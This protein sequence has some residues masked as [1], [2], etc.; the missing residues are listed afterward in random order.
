MR[1]LIPFFLIP[2]LAALPFAPVAAQSAGNY[3][4]I[5]P[6]DTK[7]E[8]I[9]KAAHV[10]PSPQQYA[11]QKMEFNA[12]IH[13]GMNTFAGVEWAKKAASPKL[14][15]PTDLNCD[16]WASVLKQAGVKMAILTAKHEDGFCL[17]PSK[18]TKYSVKY[19]PWKNGNGDV[20]RDFVDA[21]RKY[22]LKVGLYLSPW[23]QQSPVYG[24]PAYNK[25]YE[26]QLR[27]LLT[28]YGPITEVWFD[29]GIAPH[30]PKKQV[31]D[32]H[33]YYRIVRKLQPDALIA[34][35]G[36]DIRWVGTESGTGRKS[37]WDVIPVDL[38]ALNPAKLP[39]SL[40]PID[41][42]FRPHNYMGQDLGS[43]EKLYSAEGLFWYPAEADV[44]IRPG[45]F[46]HASQDTAVKSVSELVDIYFQSVGRNAVLLLN[47][48]PDKKGLIS[49]YDIKSLM[50][51]HRVISETFSRNYAAKSTVEIQGEKE[52][53]PMSSLIGNGKYWI[54]KG[55]VDT[56]SLIFS[57]PRKETFDVAMIQEQILVGQRIGKFRIDYWDKRGWRRL[58]D[59]T[60][61]G[62]KRLLRFRPVTTDRVRLV[63]E[64]SR[65]N[66]TLANFGLYE[67]PTKYLDMN[68]Q[69]GV[70]E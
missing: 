10:V 28:N 64:R 31:Y 53:A 17:W 19:S 46:F 66:P 29:G 58:A 1:L 34:I 70:G 40:H 33:A 57:L 7:A 62:Y 51:L 38:S 6:N 9:M 68:N 35:M 20:V 3:A 49:R 61:V 4:I 37:A 24:T 12:F 15:D 36:P 30:Y 16:Q 45:W 52:K 50:G 27:E 56:A 44:S 63:I 2:F 43:R 39:D 69:P 8:I 60:T 23:D 14:F 48:P 47:V 55:G 32:W 18:Y 41:E 22:G 54:A 59:G 65:L 26:N 5:G 67:L 21:C 25:Y 42:V 13:F 11:W